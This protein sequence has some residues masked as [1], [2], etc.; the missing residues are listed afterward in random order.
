[1]RQD[2]QGRQPLALSER[3]Q[4]KWQVVS[5]AG[6]EITSVSIR[7]SGEPPAHVVPIHPRHHHIQED[8]VPR[9]ARLPLQRFEA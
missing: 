3:V 9:L 8:Q 7:A 6:L 1:M 5:P 4:A 2:L